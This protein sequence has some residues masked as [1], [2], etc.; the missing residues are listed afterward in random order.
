M[1]KSP[2][3]YRKLDFEKHYRY[4]KVQ[5]SVLEKL[6]AGKP[7]KD[8]FDTL[9]LGVESEVCNAFASILLVDNSGTRLINGSVPSFT[10]I[11]KQAYNG[12]VIGPMV[13]SCGTA[14]Y[15]KKLVIV[16]DI[17][18]DPR[19]ADFKELAA[20]QGFKSCS[21]APILDSSGNVLGTFALTFTETHMP[22][23]DEL[24]VIQCSANIASLVLEKK[25]SEEN[26][27]LY[28]EEAERFAYIAS[29]DLKEPLRKII[30]FTDRLQ[31]DKFDAEKKAD[32]LRRTQASAKRLYQLTEDLFQLAKI[33]RKAMSFE[34]VDM[35]EILADVL[36]DL[37][38]PIRQTKGTVVAD[39]LPTL[40]GD[41]GQLHQ[42]LQNLI[43]NS[44]KFHREG[45][46]PHV[47]LKT[48]CLGNGFCEI[49]VIDN[50]IGIDPQYAE[51]IFEPFTR[52][53]GVQSFE[54]TGIG[55]AICGK[56][57]QCHRG[58]ISVSSEPGDGATVIIELPL[59][60]PG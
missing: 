33:G 47:E 10:E 35:N 5:N 21:S 39:P 37:E 52:L 49:R 9:T 40:E 4:L 13:G 6:A 3:E 24:E 41:R 28:A 31:D 53:H 19:W 18:T 44:L 27:K 16:E 8:I 30:L 55:L 25:R 59:S 17:S 2:Q 50:G 45:I 58:K 46:A 57:A 1:E 56:V 11:M 60:Q 34:Q 14:A 38:E 22:T 42:L 43:S 12:I 15:N 48:K 23:D 36:E 54:G 29:H 7:L 20:S 51:K 26:L 32:M